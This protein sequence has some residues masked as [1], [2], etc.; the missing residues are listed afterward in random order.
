MS[1]LYASRTNKKLYFARLHLDALVQAGN[2]TSWDKHALIESFHESVL[3]HLYGAYH[4]FLREIAQGYKLPAEQVRSALD[5]HDLLEQ[6]GYEGPEYAYIQQLLGESD[7]WL[8]MLIAEYQGC[9]RAVDKAATDQP[10]SSSEIHIVQLSA[11]HAEDGYRYEQLATWLQA[12]KAL[13]E[14]GREQLAEW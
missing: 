8:S 5:L 1:P 11:N 2:S 4:A 9:W 12:L 10:S 13:V 14:Q 3:F 6:R 7:S